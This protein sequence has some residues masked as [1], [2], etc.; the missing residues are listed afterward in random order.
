MQKTQDND[1]GI[2]EPESPSMYANPKY[3]N[4]TGW[5]DRHNAVVN[6]VSYSRT[7]FEFALVAMLRGWQ[8]YANTHRKRY[9]SLIGNDGVLGEP[10]QE[11]GRS[12]RD[13]LNGEAGRLDCGTLDAFILNTLSDNGGSDE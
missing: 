7:S 8:T 4:T 1:K 10:W 3:P 5:Q 12:I 6:Q 13:L 11:I 9:G 2:G